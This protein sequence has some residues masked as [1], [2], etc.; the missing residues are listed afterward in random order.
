[1]LLDPD[2]A[3]NR[4]LYFAYF[5]PEAGEPGGTWPLEYLYDRVFVAPLAVRRTMKI[6]IERVARARLSAD[7]GRLENVRTIATGAERRLALG[8]DNTLLVTGVDRFWRY[9]SDLDGVEQDFTA[10][11]DVRRNFA[12]RVLRVRAMAIPRTIL[13]V[14]R[15]R[16]CAD[17]RARPARSGRRRDPSGNRRAVDGGARPAGR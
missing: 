17:L 5:A 16:G 14:A 4:T 2:F 9:T 10:E 13:A 7:G 11:P 15:H 8:R 3:S 6:G 12:G 1:V